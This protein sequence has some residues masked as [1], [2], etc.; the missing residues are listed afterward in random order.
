MSTAIQHHIDR[1][2]LTQIKKFITTVKD[3]K[4]AKLLNALLVNNEVLKEVWVDENQ[5]A[6]T[7]PTPWA[8]AQACKLRDKLQARVKELEDKLRIHEPFT[9]TEMQAAFE[10]V[11][12]KSDWKKPIDIV[13]DDPGPKNLAC[14]EEAIIFYTGSTATVRELPSGRLKI[15]APGYYNTIGG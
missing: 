12:D 13:I 9:S 6:W 7:R 8:Y 15:T 11:R 2:E 5:T 10:M 1:A 3:K 14:M 4:I